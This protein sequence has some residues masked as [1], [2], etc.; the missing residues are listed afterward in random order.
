MR[1][2]A[3]VVAQLAIAAALV[4]C[5]GGAAPG[6]ATSTTAQAVSICP[7]ATIEGI[8][9]YDGNG[10][11]DWT[12][13]AGSGRA[14]VFIK[15]TQGNYDNQS[16]FAANW[17]GA[18][19]AGVLR[20]PYHFFDPTIS[21]TAQA[22]WFLDALTKQGGLQPGD[23]PPM[24]DIECPTSSTQSAT[25]PNCEYTGN[26]GWVASATMAQE[27]FDWLTAVQQATGRTPIVYSYPDWFADVGFT[28][29][30]LTQYP[31]FIATYGSSCA[32]VPAPWTSMLFWQ[33]SAT[34]TV[35]GIT[36]QVDLDRF[37]GTMAQLMGLTGAAGGDAGSE[38]AASDAASPEDASSP[39]DAGTAG[40]A[41]ATDTGSL[42]GDGSFEDEG[43][44]A[45]PAGGPKSTGGCG[46]RLGGSAPPPAGWA[47]VATMA[48]LV[49]LA[50]RRR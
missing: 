13:V 6:E 25:D 40:D 19:A 20:S 11:I 23:L 5:G 14:F 35:P 26:S 12:Q 29:A 22:T 32:D 27:I 8:D 42:Q 41:S 39:G 24:L 2:V 1:T 43:G 31:L 4:A 17:S 47:A 21:G 38:A 33:Y 50:R 9:V 37:P 7:T 48:A 36:G 28:S 34:G 46:C 45:P 16:T 30:Q 15:A 18:K 10:T 44:I 49:L 3:D